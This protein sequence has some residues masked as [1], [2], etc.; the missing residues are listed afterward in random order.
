[1]AL[2]VVCV[3]VWHFVT[4][5]VCREQALRAAQSSSDTEAQQA[6]TRLRTNLADMS[7]KMAAQEAEATA[8]LELAKDDIAALEVSARVDAVLHIVV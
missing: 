6:L 4:L 5:C 8:E 3:C 2:C 7:A 1:M